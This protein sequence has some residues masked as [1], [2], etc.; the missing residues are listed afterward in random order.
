MTNPSRSGENELMSLVAAGAVHQLNV[1]YKDYHQVLNGFFVNLG[2]D[3]QTA[4][5]LTQETFLRILRYR[6]SYRQ[7]FFV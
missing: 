4:Q 6:E 7:E 2:S 5:D 3:S 1:L